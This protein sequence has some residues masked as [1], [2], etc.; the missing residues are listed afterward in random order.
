MDF[1]S[2]LLDDSSAATSL[3]WNGRILLDSTGQTSVQWAT[4]QLVAS[5]G[6]T[7]IDYS[8]VG[9]IDA[10]V[11]RID[12]VVDPINPQDAATKAYVDAH[13]GAGT[14]TSVALADASITPIY[15]ISGSPVTS[16]GTLSLTLM[17]QTAN[18]VLAGPSSGS[19]G[20]PAFRSLVAA[21][22]PT[23]TAYAKTDLSNLIPNSGTITIT[24][25]D[26]DMNVSDAVVMT[27][28]VLQLQPFSSTPMILRFVDNSGNVFG[29]QAPNTFTT[30]T[31]LYK[32][33]LVRGSAGQV[34]STDGN[35]T[36]QLSWITP[37]G[38]S[39]TNNKELFTLSSGDITN[40]FIDLAHPG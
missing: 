1:A 5:S 23:L 29:L 22:I 36:S 9:V 20:Q 31:Q 33:P 6:A 18:T 10:S 21:D 16:S 15:S 14:V 4:R 28:P 8:T 24:A 30:T 34:L 35:P 11:N 26:I 19:P 37:S 13:S 25:V 12:N 7:M 3:D 32:L 2:R 40:Q 17:N 39:S 38:S 27:G